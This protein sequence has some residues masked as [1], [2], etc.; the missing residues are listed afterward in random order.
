MS[1]DELREMA[2]SLPH[3][4]S[5]TIK[6]VV[7]VMMTLRTMDV[8]SI[9]RMLDM[10]RLALPYMPEELKPAFVG[11]ISDMTLIK[12]F[13]EQA[14]TYDRVEEGEKAFEAVFGELKTD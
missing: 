11:M 8:D 5:E 2:K 3:G 12:V 10:H 6:Q 7:A 14:K 9:D 13:V 1:I 4:N